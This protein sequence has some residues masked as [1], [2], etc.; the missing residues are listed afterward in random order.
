MMVTTSAKSRLMKPGFVI[1]SVIPLTA[2][3]KTSF[4][5]LN[6]VMIDMLAPK[7]LSNLSLSMTINESTCFESSVMPDSALTM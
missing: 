4:A 6:A 5:A 1:A 2:F 7:F 3:N